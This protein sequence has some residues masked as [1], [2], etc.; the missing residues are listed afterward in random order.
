MAKKQVTE[1]KKK[2]KLKTKIEKGI[3]NIKST[4]NNT[5]ISISD[6]N[7]RVNFFAVVYTHDIDSDTRL[8]GVYTDNANEDEGCWYSTDGSRKNFS[9]ISSFLLDSSISDPGSLCFDG[10]SLWL[11]DTDVPATIYKIDAT[12]G[13]IFDSFDISGIIEHPRNL[14]WDDKS[15]WCLASDGLYQLDTL[16]AVIS[17]FTCE[18]CRDI[19]YVSGYIWCVDPFTDRLQKIDPS[20]GEVVKSYN[21]TTEFPAGFAFDGNSLWV[22]D[23]GSSYH[24]PLIFKVDLEGKILDKYNSP[25]SWPFGL[26]FGDSYLYCV[27]YINNRIYKLGI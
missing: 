9:S 6:V 23:M 2:K 22:C 13:M 4:F 19:T 24:W 15:L 12:N 7:G 20:S 14:A 3:V 1:V 21:F 27:D 17:F 25:C 10:N 5:I 18:T 8:D 26:A 16:C 11:L